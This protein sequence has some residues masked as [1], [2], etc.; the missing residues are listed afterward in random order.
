M[1]KMVQDKLQSKN[2][3]CDGFANMVFL[4]HLTLDDDQFEY[5]ANALLD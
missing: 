3:L 2:K 5:A 4:N 1:K